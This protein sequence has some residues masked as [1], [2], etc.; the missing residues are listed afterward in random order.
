MPADGFSTKEARGEKR[1][2]HREVPPPRPFPMQAL[3]PLLQAAEAIQART[4]VPP[5][6]AAQSV[7]AAATLAVQAHADVQLPHGAV[8][9]LVCSTRSGTA[10]RSAGSAL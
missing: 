7:L 2:L 4:Q 5:A 6:L 1:P 8:R 3:G 9:P 10:L